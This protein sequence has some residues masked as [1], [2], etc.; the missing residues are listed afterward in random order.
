MHIGVPTQYMTGG[1]ETSGND[2]M[3]TAKSD[4]NYC[5]LAA[6]SVYLGGLKLGDE[7]LDMSGLG[8]IFIGHG[9]DG[10]FIFDDSHEC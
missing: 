2:Q 5:F 3:T 10:Y 8:A 9:A 6:S 4:A 7:V 1:K